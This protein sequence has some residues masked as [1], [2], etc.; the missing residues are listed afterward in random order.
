M[1]LAQRPAERRQHLLLKHKRSLQI[2]LRKRPVN[3]ESI[4]R[5]VSGIV[6][7]VENIGEGEYNFLLAKVK[8]NRA[9]AF[10]DFGDHKSAVADR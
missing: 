8:A 7:R 2:A 4:D 5:L 9:A 3:Q 6:R 1:L 10:F